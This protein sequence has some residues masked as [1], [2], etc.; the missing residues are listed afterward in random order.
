MGIIT[1]QTPRWLPA[2]LQISDAA[3]PTGSYAHSFGL[4]ELVRQ[5]Q[6]HDEASLRGFLYE[7]AIP[8]LTHVDLP[9]VRESRAAAMAGARPSEASSMT[10]GGTW[11]TSFST[12][13]VA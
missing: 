5:G 3:F 7:H 4:E 2:L 10:K 12:L 11:R 9:L 13:R 6:V 8:G 1:E